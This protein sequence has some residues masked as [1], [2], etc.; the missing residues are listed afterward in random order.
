MSESF[1]SKFDPKDIA[2]LDAR[3]EKILQGADT[4]YEVNMLVP[5]EGALQFIETY[6]MA[7]G[8]DIL[9]MSSL[10]ALSAIIA[11]SLMTS[12]ENDTD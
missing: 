11:Q 5:R 2:D 4:Y 7:L 3:A 9:A 12:I 8:G 1:F 6:E 10:M